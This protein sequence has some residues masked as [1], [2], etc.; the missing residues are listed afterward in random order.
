MFNDRIEEIDKQILDLHRLKQSFN[1]V[2]WANETLPDLIKRIGSCYKYRN[3]YSC[4]KIDDDYWWVYYKIVGIDPNDK[5][6]VVESFQQCVPNGIHYRKVEFETRSEYPHHFDNT[7][8]L[9][10]EPEE[11]EKQRK[12]VIANLKKAQMITSPQ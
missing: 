12:M 4:P 10:V 11:Y 8:Y 7:D 2:I 1:D 9:A 3:C 6:L 5:Q